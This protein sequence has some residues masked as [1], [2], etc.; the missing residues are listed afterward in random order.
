MMHLFAP[1][2]AEIKE[3]RTAYIILNAAYYGLIAT[4][5]VAVAFKPAVQQHLIA[6]V[7]HAFMASGPSSHTVNAYKSGNVPVAIMLTFLVNLLGGA[8]ACITLPSLLLPFSGLVM[9]LFRATLWG[10]VLSPSSAKLAMTMIPHSLTLVIE[11][12]AYILA[13]FA[14]YIQGR[15]FLWP[16]SIGAQTHW[17]GYMAGLRRTL[18]IYP[19]IIA[20]LAVSAVYEALE[21]IYIVPLLT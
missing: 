16:Q 6:N 3:R 13:M 9:G 7:R 19:L 18:N 4:A 8:F 17:Q 10:L 2:W 5:M 12:Q 15:A 14:A 20:L 11:G 1:A 21:V